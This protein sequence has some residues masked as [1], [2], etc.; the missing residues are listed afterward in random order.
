[1][2]AGGF[3]EPLFVL[4]VEA[5]AVE[6]ALQGTGFTRCVEELAFVFVY[7]GN[8]RDLPLAVRDLRLPA[9]IRVVEIQVQKA[10]ALAAPEEL[11]AVF[12]E[13]KEVVDI[14]PVGIL[15][16]E[17]RVAVPVEAAAKSRSR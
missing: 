3:R 2:R 10:V 1:M 7:T 5:D 9:S 15:L 17:D 13:A 8:S 14:D 12:E 11:L 4:P 6:L 16:V